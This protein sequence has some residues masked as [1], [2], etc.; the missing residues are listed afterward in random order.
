MP[1][2]SDPRPRIPRGLVPKVLIL[3]GAFTVILI[4]IGFALPDR[5]T[6]ERSVIIEAPPARIQPHVADFARWTAWQPWARRDD[7]AKFAHHGEAGAGQ[8]FTWDGPDL[9]RGRI[10]MTAVAPTRVDMVLEFRAGGVRPTGA[11][12]LEPT[13]GGATRVTWRIAG[14]TTFRPIGNYLGLLMDGIIG[15]DLDAGLVGLKRVVSAQ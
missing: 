5:Y 6:V 9:G 12:L 4:A 8:T 15:P 11:I 3:L 2:A 14:E 10:E 1:D 13:D 7:E